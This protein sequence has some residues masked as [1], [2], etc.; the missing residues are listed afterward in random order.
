MKSEKL[1]ITKCLNCLPHPEFQ[2]R[3]VIGTIPKEVF[4]KHTEF[5]AEYRDDKQDVEIVCYRLTRD[6]KNKRGYYWGK[7]DTNTNT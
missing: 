2:S 7:D 4:L 5:R 1:K 6:Q 3:Y